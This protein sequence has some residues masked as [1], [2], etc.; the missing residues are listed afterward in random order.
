MAK[1]VLTEQEKSMIAMLWKNYMPLP[2]I[3]NE[4]GGKEDEKN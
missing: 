1:D 2:A 3:D 4:R